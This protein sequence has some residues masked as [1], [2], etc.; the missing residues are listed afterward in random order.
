MTLDTVWYTRCPIPTALGLADRLGTLEKVVTDAGLKLGRVQQA[1]DAA[2]QNTHFTQA[3]RGALR[4]GGNIPSIW[5][6]STGVDIRV[7][8]LS[9]ADTPH[10]VL[11]RSD[12]DIDSVEKL[13]GRK[14]AL[15]HR[16]NDAIDFW[17]ATGLRVFENVLSRAGLSLSDVDIHEIPV[18]RSYIDNGQRE[19][20]GGA[21]TGLARSGSLQR[22]EVAALIRGEA[23]AIFSQ[24]S[25]ST[26]VLEYFDFRVLADGGNGLSGAA[27]NAAPAILTMDGWIVDERPDVAA[28]IVKSV[29]DASH[30]AKSSPSDAVRLIASEQGV[31]EHVLEQTYARQPIGEQLGVDLSREK[32]AALG[33]Q[34]DF[35]LQHGFINKRIDLDA[36]IDRRPLEQALRKA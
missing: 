16:Q 8:G 26:E 2:T 27:N 15:A 7:V 18:Q 12:S 14:I 6:K 24:C 17:R 23:D 22:E 31:A 1:R 10:P 30:W 28:E 13:K 19:R 11:V 32:I 5:S 33:S 36:W 4:H 35:L 25:F 20:S 9:W 34:I 29:I 21:R 3:R